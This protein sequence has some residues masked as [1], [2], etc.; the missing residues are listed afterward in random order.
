MRC[1]DSLFIHTQLPGPQLLS[2]TRPPMP[3][4]DPCPVLTP[5]SGL[6]LAWNSLRHAPI[7]PSAYLVSGGAIRGV[8]GDV[9]VGVCARSQFAGGHFLFFWR[10][11]G[12]ASEY[13]KIPRARTRNL[14]GRP[15]Q[16]GNPSAHP[17]W[18]KLIFLFLNGMVHNLFHPRAR[19]RS[20]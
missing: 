14:E 12:I 20:I 6:C 11:Y 18:G 19:T 13:K 4:N 17:I 3:T 10:W 7:A 9:W 1:L 16:G 8:C 2:K 5:S 15:P